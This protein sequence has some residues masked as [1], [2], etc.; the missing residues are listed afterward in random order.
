MSRLPKAAIV[1]VGAFA[2]LAVAVAW[3]VSK[4]GASSPSDAAP[5]DDTVVAE[6]P[7][8][9]GDE[10]AESFLRTVPRPMT[11]AEAGLII[12]KDETFSA[13]YDELYDNRDK[14][15]GRDIEVAGYVLR[16]AGLE[17]GAFLLGRDLL[18][19]CEDDLYFIGFVVA[20]ASQLPAD[21]TTVRVR[22][23]IEARPYTDPESGKTFTVPAV[24]AERIDP[25]P[26]VPRRV[27]PN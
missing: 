6:R 17:P 13:A 3:A 7:S 23:R 4:P 10:L 27:Y 22:G 14:Y 12:V 16:E 8:T 26:G 18:W 2:I 9:I 15:Y 25:E 11:I 24:I 5:S 1:V 19:C 21:D 20:S